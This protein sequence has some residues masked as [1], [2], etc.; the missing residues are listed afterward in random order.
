MLLKKCF[1]FIIYFPENVWKFLFYYDIII[2]G[3]FRKLCGIGFK[4][5]FIIILEVDTNGLQ[6]RLF[7]LRR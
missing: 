6:V 1:K 5:L 7:V 2:D 4:S 3:L